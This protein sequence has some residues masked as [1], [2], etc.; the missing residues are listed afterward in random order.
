M[1]LFSDIDWVIVLV[2]AVFLLFGQQNGETLR[3]LGRWYGR[4]GRLKQELLG[5]FTRAADLPPP[6][7]NLTIRGALLG[8]DPPAPPTRGVPAAVARPAPSPPLVGYPAV[9]EPSTGGYA[10]PTWS[11]TV[12]PIPVQEEVVR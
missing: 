6:G 12:T 5:E 3:T 9:W 7:G 8:L 4:A 11:S 1:A 2:A 10:T